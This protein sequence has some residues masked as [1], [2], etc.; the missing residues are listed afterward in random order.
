[1]TVFDRVILNLLNI[2][3]IFALLDQS[4]ILLF[5][6]L[7]LA[8]RLLDAKPREQADPVAHQCKQR[9]PARQPLCQTDNVSGQSLRIQLLLQNN[10]EKQCRDAIDRVSTSSDKPYSIYSLFSDRNSQAY[11]RD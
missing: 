4:L 8:A 10:I 3:I 11:L 6:H 5:P 9:L 2:S 1:M 7:Q